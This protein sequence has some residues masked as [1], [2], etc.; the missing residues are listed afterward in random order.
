MADLHTKVLTLAELKQSGWQSVTVKEEIRRNLICRVKKNEK[1]FEGILGYDKTVLP[2]VQHAILSHHDM[3]LLGLRGQ[4]KTRILRNLVQFL[5]EYMPIVEGSEIN[6]DPYN[7]LS[8][9]AKE[10]VAT[11]G[12]E[13]PISWVHRSM[14]YGEKLATPDT[15]VADLIGDIDPIKA[16]TN[17]LNLADDRVI[18][19]GLIPR[20]NRGIF[21]INELPDLQP[22]IQVALLNIMQERDIQIR[23]FNVRI[24]ID[25]FMAFSANP[26]DYTNRGSIITPL[27]DRIDA[28]IITHYPKVLETGINITQQEAWQNRSDEILVHIPTI[29]REII[30]RTAFEARDS[31]YVDQK[32]GVSTR[33]TI[34]ALEQVISSAERRAILNNEQKTS[35]RIADIFHMVPALTG[36]LELVYEGEQEG[37]A[38]VAK[39]II[40]KAINKTF[41]NHF[42]DPQSKRESEKAVYKA[43][44][45]WFASGNEINL[46]DT[47]LSKEYETLLNSIPK[48]KDLVTNFAKG[49]IEA[50]TFAIM[51]LAL[52]ALHQNSMLSKQDLDDQNLYSDML[53]SMFSSLGGIEDDFENFDS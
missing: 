10:L 46:P 15:T 41:K 20:T 45:D 49:A 30:E 5:D 35:V 1:L 24:P 52:E 13:T 9:Y 53:G 38:K 33:M 17:R 48:L 3:I 22:R 47:L 19:F 21:V 40:G 32:S 12:D 31:E 26:E 27:K 51:D 42:P 34:T 8:R 6:D 43:I 39:H 18:N 44:T 4:A 23:G 2:Q 50:D 25:V 29:Y 14:R 7:P 36:K 16:A 28:Q 37:A 11:K